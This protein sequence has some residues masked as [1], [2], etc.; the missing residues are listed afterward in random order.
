MSRF[1][2]GTHRPQSTLF[3]ERIEDYIT[4]TNPVKVIDAFVDALDLAELGFSSAHPHTTGRP[5]YHPALMLKLYIYGYLNKIQSSRRLEREAN[6]NLEL[7]WLLNRLTPDFKTIADFRKDNGVGIKSCCRQFVMLCKQLNL[8]ADALIA[9]DGSRFKAVNNRDRN[10]TQAKVK[11]RIEAIDKSVDRYLSQLESLDRQDRVV[12]P[13]KTRHIHKQ[14]DALKRQMAEV[15]A[16]EEALEITPGKQISL[17]DPD[18]RA[19]ST[20][21]RSSGNVGYNVQ[22]AVDTKHHLIVAHDVSIAMGDRRMLTKMSV[23]AR[24]ATGIN[25]LEVIA[26]RGYFAMEEIKSTVD[27]GITPYVPKTVTSSN[28]KK[29][30]YDRRDFVYVEEDDEYKCP[31]GERLARQTKTMAGNMLMYRYW[32][33]HC[34]SCTLKPKCTVGKERR[35]TRW[36]HGKVIETHERRMEENP[37][38]MQLRKQTVEHPFGTIKS[39]M[40]MTHFKTKRLKNVATEMSLH[41]LAYNITRM[42]NI[43]GVKPLIRAI[44]A[45]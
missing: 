12:P 44:E 37:T 9:I 8:F 38:M 41:V 10:Y 24:E 42:I 4:E 6:R 36:E 33:K 20:N 25:N 43:I 5:A 22:A 3:P 17:T 26:D 28:R 21:A 16:I 2:E 31:A 39:W 7:M 23:K 14:L 18:A 11:R 32:Y 30:L 19:M 45:S 13:A 29:G 34:G 40:G 35:V 15:K 27:V 1:I